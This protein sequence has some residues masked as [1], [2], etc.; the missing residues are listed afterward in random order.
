MQAKFFSETFQNVNYQ[1]LNQ[2][3]PKDKK[4]DMKC[5]YQNGTSILD[6]FPALR[7]SFRTALLDQLEDSLGLALRLHLGS[8]VDH[9]LNSFFPILCRAATLED[10]FGTMEPKIVFIV[11]N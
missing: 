4:N 9:V 2:I 11:R 5:V 7:F 8:I 6:W 3:Y 1:I 10:M